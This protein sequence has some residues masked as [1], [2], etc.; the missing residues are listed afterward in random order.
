MSSRGLAGYDPETGKF[1]CTKCGACCVAPAGYPAYEIGLNRHDIE[2]LEA[3]G[4]M[5]LIV[6]S[7]P[8][9]KGGFELE[10]GDMRTKEGRTGQIR[11]AGLR[12]SVGC[13]ATCSIYKAR[14]TVCRDFQPGSS[15]CLASRRSVLGSHVTRMDP[16]E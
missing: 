11:C 6:Y 15:Y 5:R 14:P 4:A 13:D 16:K 3:S 2:R 1:D 12:G 9:G 8:E 7:A 10:F